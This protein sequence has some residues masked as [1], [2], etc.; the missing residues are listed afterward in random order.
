[1]DFSY[2]F[3]AVK[4]I[5]ANKEYYITMIPLRHLIRILPEPTEYVPPE[6]RAQRRLNET[7]IPEIKKYILENRDSYI[8]SSLTA[9]IDGDFVFHSVCEN[10]NIGILEISMDSKILIND[11]QHRRAAITQALLDDETLGDE[12]ISV[13]FFAD[14]GLKSSQQMFTDLNKHAVKTSNSISELYDS[15]DEI[16]IATRNV[17]E[18]IPFL[19]SYTDKEKDNLGKFSSNLFTLN[20]FYSANKN[21]V[22]GIRKQKDIEKILYHFWSLIA[23]NISEWKE[24]QDRTL[25]KVDIRENYVITQAVIIKAFGLVG[26]YYAEHMEDIPDEVFSVLKNVNWKRDN[27]DLMGRIINEKGRIINSENAICLASNYI[28]RLL[29]FSLDETE[30]AKEDSL[31]R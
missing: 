1:M 11:G 30:I 18:T 13:V 20:M 19:S 8:F 15:R 10:N 29:Q 31:K 23:D 14:E 5:Q 27:K 24:V 4:G 9:S 2:K 28:K 12:T 25:S 26:K 3:P 7:R 16:A 22:K 21:I 6:F 17:I